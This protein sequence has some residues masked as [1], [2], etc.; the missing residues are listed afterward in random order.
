MAFTL[1]LDKDWDIYTDD[2]GQIAT[3]ETDIAVAQNVSNAVRL[4]TGD[5]CLNLTR[6]VPHFSSDV[7]TRPNVP[8]IASVLLRASS[9]VPEVEKASVKIGTMDGRVIPGDIDIRTTS[10]KTVSA[11][12]GTK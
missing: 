2:A 12:R 5:A 7:S 6:G 1:A 11:P 4:F 9:R 8:F 10:G 3:L